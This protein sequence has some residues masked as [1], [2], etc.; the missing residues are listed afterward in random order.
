MKVKEIKM[1][2][3]DQKSSIKQCFVSKGD[4]ARGAAGCQA[5]CVCS[6]WTGNWKEPGKIFL[7]LHIHEPTYKMVMIFKNTLCKMWLVIMSNNERLLL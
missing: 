1:C 4:T 6:W 5:L 3:Y 7:L 2:F